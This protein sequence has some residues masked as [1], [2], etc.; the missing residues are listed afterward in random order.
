MEG[1]TGISGAKGNRAGI[2]NLVK[3]SVPD[4]SLL[5]HFVV[6]DYLSLG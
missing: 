4:I 2:E 6:S 3:S 1:N 5:G